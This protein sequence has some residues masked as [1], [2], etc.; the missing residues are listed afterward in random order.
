MSSDHGGSLTRN[1]CRRF[2]FCFLAALLRTGAATSARAAEAIEGT[3]VLWGT[4]TAEVPFTAAQVYARN[5]DENMLYTVF[6]GGG[7]Y[8][9]INLMPAR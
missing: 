2:V 8:R 7:Q 1:V 5:L 4:V 6:T 9:A 3:A